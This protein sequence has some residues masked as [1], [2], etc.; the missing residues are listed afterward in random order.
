MGKKKKA[1]QKKKAEKNKQTPKYS[2]D[3]LI[4]KIEE[5]LDCFEFDLAVK[6]CEKAISIAPENLKVIE[7][8]GSVYAEIEDYEKSKECFTKAVELSPDE[9]HEKYMYLGQI[10][11]GDMA[12]GWYLKGIEIMKGV[13]G[14]DDDAEKVA[15][16]TASKSLPTGTDIS[17]AYCALAEI[18]MT[19][20]CFDDD[21]EKEC[22]K[23]CKEAIS[24][25]SKNIDAYIVNAN[26][27]LSQEKREEA[28][29]VLKESFEL[30][31]LKISDDDKESDENGMNEDGENGM[32]EEEG[33]GGTQ[34]VEDEGDD[35][36]APSYP[37]RVSLSKLLTEVGEYDKAE[38][39][40]NRLIEENDEDLE[41]WY[42]LGWNMF[43]QDQFEDSMFL[44]T[45]A[46]ELYERMECND[47]ELL[48]HL[49]ELLETCKLKTNVEGTDEGMDVEE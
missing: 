5:Y 7:T 33:K 6:F 22:E 30:L 44:L 24:W 18:F 20:S 16:A 37:S 47:E 36:N 11:S 3:D 38:K 14:T 41:V 28:A 19:D 42:M 26:F 10:S 45:K 4:D 27:L 29:N 43:L 9:G 31:N 13:V 1:G 17:N 46:K 39:L 2:A 25:N 35:S 48:G 21:A 15:S 23:Y 49:N 40:M 12:K 34:E 32:E 8:A